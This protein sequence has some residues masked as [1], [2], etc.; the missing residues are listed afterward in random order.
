MYPFRSLLK[1]GKQDD[2]LRY[3]PG[4]KGERQV[5]ST[6]TSSFLGLGLQS[7]PQREPS[8]SSGMAFW[9]RCGKGLS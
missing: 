7:F 3:F 5:S 2:I 4:F 8:L 1:P 6:D 9:G